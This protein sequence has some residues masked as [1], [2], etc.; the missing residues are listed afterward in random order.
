MTEL[1]ELIYMGCT[2][3]ILVAL[4]L[5]QSRLSRRQLHQDM[6]IELLRNLVKEMT[7]HQANTIKLLAETRTQLALMA[8]PYE[9]DAPRENLQ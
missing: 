3:A 2:G 1:N 8:G 7:D 5:M 9:P 6:E 4:V